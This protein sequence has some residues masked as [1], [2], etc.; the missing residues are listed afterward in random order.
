MD[1]AGA[2]D[3][4]VVDGD[5]VALCLSLEHAIPFAVVYEIIRREKRGLTLVGPISDIAFDMLI[6]AG[7]ASRVLAA[8]VGNVSYG[9]GYNFSRSVERGEVE[10]VDYS[11]LAIASA[12]LAGAL[13]IPYIP[14]KT[15]VGSDILEGLVSKGYAKLGRCPFT[16]EE[17]VMLRALK[18]DVAIIHVQRCDER[19]YAQLWGN[20]GVVRE[21]CQASRRVIVT[22]EE[23]I[24]HEVV[25]QRPNNIVCPPHKVVAVTQVRYG[26][27]PSPLMGYYDRDHEFFREY[28]EMS[29]TPERFREWLEKWVYSVKSREEYLSMVDLDRIKADAGGGV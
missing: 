7:C 4:F 10:V 19:G 2:V 23:I 12:L 20:Y 3:E 5:S 14:T 27:H 21:A 16:D 28:Y 25:K 11:N 22:A 8:W 18:P 24:P 17:L 1:L 13:G 15:L 6:G 29:K 9:V 26:A